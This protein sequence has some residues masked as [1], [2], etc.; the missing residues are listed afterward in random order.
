MAADMPPIEG[1][2]TGRIGNNAVNACFTPYDGHYFYHR[3]L[4]GIALSKD[5]ASDGGW[6]ERAGKWQ[7]SRV[8]EN[9]LEAL[10]LGGGKR[11]TIRLTRLGPLDA[12]GA[13]GAAYYA[14]VVNGVKYRY[15]EGKAGAL[16]LRIVKSPLGQAFELKGNSP[17]IG[18]IN[19]YTRRW[20]QNQA[21]NAFSCKV[22]GGEDWRSDLTAEKVIGHYL[23]AGEN[24]PDNYCGGPHGNS[25]QAKHLFDLRTGQ[26]FNTWSWLADSEAS[27]KNGH[28][29]RKLIEK[30]NTRGDCEGMAYEIKAP[31]PT[32]AGLAFATS[33]PHA[34][35]ACNEDIVLSYAK[36][37]PYLSAEG[38]AFV[39]DLKR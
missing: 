4:A 39:K 27:L 22:N 25:M 15:R 29:L 31:Y 11:L 5:E 10:W 26:P 38:K 33:H 34:G 23:L 6:Q 9:E 20:L 18:N 1:A 17:A 36:L 21:V 12:G 19:A 32:A 3:H 14:P 8:T 13:C 28:A 2:W 24:E 30:L 16:P 7:V 35:R 37:A